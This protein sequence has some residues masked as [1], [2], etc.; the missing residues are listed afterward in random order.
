MGAVVDSIALEPRLT[1]PID[2]LVGLVIDRKD[3]RF[4]EIFRVGSVIHTPGSL[5]TDVTHIC[6]DG[7]LYGAR[8]LHTSVPSWRIPWNER[9]VVSPPELFYRLDDLTHIQHRMALTGRGFDH[10]CTQYAAL[11]GDFGKLKADYHALFGEP[12]PRISLNN[13]GNNRNG[14]N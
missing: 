4:R 3:V 2:H 1:I 10:F 8:Y 11:Q 7:V 6:P 13:C 9:P 5:F 12:F 14:R